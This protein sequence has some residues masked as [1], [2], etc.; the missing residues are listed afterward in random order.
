MSTST[1]LNPTAPAIHRSKR[2]ETKRVL[3]ISYAFPPVGGAGVQRATKFTK[4]LGQF[5]WQPT[6]LT[7]ANPSVP[8]L[9]RSLEADLPSDV[10]VVRARSW[11]PDYKFKKQAAANAEHAGKSGLV[12][13]K[14]RLIRVAGRVASAVLQPDPQILWYPGALATGKQLLQ[15][16]NFD[17]IF[18]TAPPFSTLLVGA[19]LA[20]H[21]RLPLVVDYRDEWTLSNKYWE[22]KKLGP[23]SNWVQSRMERRVLRTASAV[24]ATTRSSAEALREHCAAASSKATVSWIYNGYDGDDFAHRSVR[25]CDDSRLRLVYTGTLWNLT[26]VAPLVAAVRQLAAQSPELASR[27]D[28]VFL[29]RRTDAEKAHLELL[30]DLP[31]GLITHDYLDHS[32]ALDEMCGADANLLLLSDVPGAGRVVPAKLFEYMA[33]R[34]PILALTPLGESWQLL[35]QYPL[36][37]RFNPSDADGVVD[38]LARAIKNSAAFKT[39]VDDEE[40]RESQFDRR[41]QAGQL[42]DILNACCGKSAAPDGSA[43]QELAEEVSAPV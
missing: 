10:L 34:R 36:A 7:V 3:L 15:Q 22:N 27:L 12:T 33:S 20:R 4:Y 17:A 18:V 38:W 29:G 6:V 41:F 2:I 42:A 19:A 25:P 16:E 40:E 23:I 24:L 1:T 8:V 32:A 14:Q 26:S 11:E 31:C 5:G 39:A 43:E 9:D 13:A 37:Y 21:T 35:D 28:L 30:N